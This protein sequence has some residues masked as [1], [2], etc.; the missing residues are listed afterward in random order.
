[1]LKPGDAAGDE[2]ALERASRTVRFNA[3]EQDLLGRRQSMGDT[4]VFY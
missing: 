1:M 3:V 2:G 4:D